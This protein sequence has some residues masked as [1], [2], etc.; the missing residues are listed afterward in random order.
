M[1]TNDGLLFVLYSFLPGDYLITLFGSARVNTP[2][3][4][5]VVYERVLMFDMRE[6]MMPS[7][8]NNFKIADL[9]RVKQRSLLIVMVLAMVL[10]I[11]VS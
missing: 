1:V 2:S 4:T 9:I 7:V 6:S 5:I 8:M 11:G 3:W 10:A